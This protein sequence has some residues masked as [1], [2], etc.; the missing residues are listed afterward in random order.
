MAQEPLTDE[1]TNMFREYLQR[2]EENTRFDIL[3]EMKGILNT[4]FGEQNNQILKPEVEDIA[5]YLNETAYKEDELPNKISKPLLESKLVKW[6]GHYTILIYFPEVVITNS[7]KDHHTIRELYVKIKVSKDGLF[8]GSMRG[9]RTC[10]TEAELRRGYF[11]SHLHSFSPNNIKFSSFCLGSGEINL[12]MS[13]LRSAYD[14]INFTL[15]C[16]HLKSYVK[17]ESIEG[18]P[19]T[20]MSNIE[21]RAAS[22]TDIMSTIGSA[23]L[24]NIVNI[25]YKQ[26]IKMPL[27][28]KHHLFNYSISEKGLVVTA[29]EALEKKLA[30]LIMAINPG[31]IS[32]GSTNLDWM[33]VVKDTTGGYCRLNDTEA[34][35]ERTP[36]TPILVFK[37][38]PKIFK[39]IEIKEIKKIEKYANPRITEVLC[40]RLSCSFTKEAV[41]HGS[42]PWKTHSSGGEPQTSDPNPLSLF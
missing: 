23:H 10:V 39:V 24:D 36:K 11:H 41:K 16:L 22:L 8:S 27:E 3:K 5:D 7:K 25:L 35:I 4:S 33:L 6:N 31:L 34:R 1:A 32:T 2:F 12:P 40:W 30:E 9:V 21:T 42:S 29:T 14:K 19:Y 15:F 26:I 17:W 38:E 18:S 20:F 37:G 28:A 13:M